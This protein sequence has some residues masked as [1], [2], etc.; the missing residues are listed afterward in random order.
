MPRNPDNPRRKYWTPEREARLVE[1][2]AEGLIFRRIAREMDPGCTKNMALAKAYRL[3]LSNGRMSDRP[4]PAPEP[5]RPVPVVYPAR[6]DPDFP[7]RCAHP[8]CRN[9]KQHNPRHFCAEHESE[10]LNRQTR[11]RANMR[12]VSLGSV[13]SAAV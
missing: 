5:P 1:L 11:M 9:P 4:P 13:M 8:G 2:C 3:N 10:Y 12:E 6:P 7:K